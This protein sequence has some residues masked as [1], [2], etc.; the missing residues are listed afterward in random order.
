MTPSDLQNDDHH[1]DEIIDAAENTVINQDVIPDSDAVQPDGEVDVSAVTNSHDGASLDATSE[2]ADDDQATNRDADNDAATGED[3]SAEGDDTDNVEGQNE[4]AEDPVD[5]DEQ[6]TESD[7][8]ELTANDPSSDDSNSFNTEEL[9]GIVE[10]LIFGAEEALSASRICDII[11]D[12]TGDRP[13]VEMIDDAV[14]WLN[15][16]YESSQRSFRIRVWGGGYRMATVPEYAAFLKAMYYQHRETRLSRSLLETLAILAY[17][18]PATKPEIDHIR[19]V[20][21]DYAIRRLMELSFVEI[22]GRSEGVGKPLLYRTTEL[23][24]DKFGLA[25]LDDLPTLREMDE[26]L[27]DPS[28]SSEKA[29]LL[30]KRGLDLPDDDSGASNETSANAD[31]SVMPPADV[32]AEQ[33]SASSGDGAPLGTDSDSTDITEGRSESDEL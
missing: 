3:I 5:L 30:M 31:I 16:V 32:I 27:N 28:F 13:S 4:D 18:Q 17:K 11:V 10:A 22:S 1:S 26:L 6:A 23:F 12:T 14:D 25:S 2:T 9:L 15:S 24:M 21:S 33:V 19:G 29:H 7:S 20:D 8:P